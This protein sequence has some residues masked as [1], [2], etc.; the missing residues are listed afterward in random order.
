M[1]NLHDGF[2]DVV[3]KAYRARVVHGVAVAADARPSR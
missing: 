2:D 1:P 3:Q